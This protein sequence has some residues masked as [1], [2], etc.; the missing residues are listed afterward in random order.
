MDGRRG[1]WRQ[2]AASVA[3]TVLGLAVAALGA[4]EQAAERA[5]QRDAKALDWLLR[6]G[7]EALVPAPVIEPVE[8]QQREAQVDQQAKQMERF[9]QP[10]LASELEL[11]RGSCGG[12]KPADRQRI[13]NTGRGAVT[14]TARG[15]A[16]RQLTGRLGQDAYEPREEIRKRLAAAVAELATPEESA[17][18][19]V[20]VGQRQARHAEAARTAIVARLDRQLDLT[21]AQRQAIEAGLERNWNP[22]WLQELDRR[23]QVRINDYPIAPDQ[24]AAAIVPHLDPAQA[25][26]WERWCRAAGSRMAPNHFNWSFD[27]QGLQQPDGWW[28][29]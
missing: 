27:G 12:L 18:Y 13:L 29:R 21:A 7:I 1:G 19:Q 6:Q 22:G 5:A 2:A 10:M 15:F 25:A 8:N 23:G 14:T 20:A 9:F 16:E 17:A 26:E 4:D 3:A 24:A 28:G 11:I